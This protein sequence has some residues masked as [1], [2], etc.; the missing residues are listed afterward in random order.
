MMKG[1][2]MMM[3]TRSSSFCL[4]LVH[5]VTVMIV[6]MIQAGAELCQAQDKLNWAV[7]G[8]SDKLLL[9]S[10]FPF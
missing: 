5:N 6:M 8:W 4:F 10:A 3:M 7:L 9:F 1:K 2:I